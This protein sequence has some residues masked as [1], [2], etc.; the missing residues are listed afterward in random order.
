MNIGQRTIWR[1]D[2]PNTIIDRPLADATKHILYKKAKAGN[3][4]SA[5]ELSD[6]LITDTGLKKLKKLIGRRKVTFVPVHAEENQ[7]K[8]KIPLA[9]AF[10]LYKR[11]NAKL[12]TEIIQATKVSR[13]G[14]N[15]WYRLANPPL[16]D[17]K[18]TKNSLVIMIDDTQTQ[19]GTFASL[20]GHIEMQDS[21]VIGAYALTG[22]QYSV[23]L[24]LSDKT[25]KQLRGQYESIENWW[26]QAFGY[27]FEHLTEWEAR[28]SINSGKTPKQVRDSITKA[29]LKTRR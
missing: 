6:Y 21:I 9:V 16:F 19:G 11:L 14:N 24:R 10:I 8:N 1:K 29:R 5:F 3:T 26:Q 15:G 17:G 18:I 13:T 20:K 23:Q 27:G 2:F 28:Y 25:L 7:G 4:D 12:N 22:K